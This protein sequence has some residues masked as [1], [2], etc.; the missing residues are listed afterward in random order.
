MIERWGSILLVIIVLGGWVGLGRPTRIAEA[1]EAGVLAAP[2]E[3]EAA[4]QLRS[5]QRTQQATRG[6]LRILSSGTRCA[7]ARYV[8][9][10]RSDREPEIVDQWYVVSQLWADAALLAADDANP[11]L[12]AATRASARQ[13]RAQTWNED[14]ARCHLDKGFVFLDR[15]WDD[16]DGGYYPR[17]NANGSKITRK[18]Q[19]ADDNALAGLAL[20]AAADSADDGFT[21][22]YYIYAAVQEAEYLQESG[23]WDDTFGG[24]FWWNT[25]LGDTDEGKPAQT[26]ALA[27]LFFAR[28]FAVT[29]D[30]AYRDAATSTPGRPS[31]VAVRSAQNATSTTTRA[32]R[33]RRCWRWLPL[34]ATRTRSRGQRRSAS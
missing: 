29:G 21:R 23:L 20:L 5:A 30:P 2:A 7:D 11:Q 22:D 34:T 4:Q 17:S 26:N 24:G 6:S 14:E 16:D 32:S 10:R 33:L 12:R 1:A 15:L 3:V 9:Y 25:G 27:A 19:Y 31:A 8:A 13:S 28:L 18:A